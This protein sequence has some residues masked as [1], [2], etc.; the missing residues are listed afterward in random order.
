MYAPHQHLARSEHTVFTFCGYIDGKSADDLY[1]GFA[2]ADSPTQ[3]IESLKE[4]GVVV[5]AISSLAD[6]EQA[7]HILELIAARSSEIDSTEFIN[8]Y[9]GRPEVFPDVCT[10]TFVGYIDDPRDMRAGYIVGPDEQFVK[11]YLR[12]AAD[13]TVASIVSLAD[14]RKQHSELLEIA[15]DDREILTTLV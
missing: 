7:L 6:V 4:H 14:L 9:P 3:A 5:E 8:V 11:D 12:G 2:V 1:S 15:N 13:L 10:F